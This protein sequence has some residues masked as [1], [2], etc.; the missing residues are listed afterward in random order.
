MVYPYNGII[1]SN[2]KEY[3]QIQRDKK[4]AND[5]LGPEWEQRLTANGHNTFEVAINVLKLDCNDDFTMLLI[6]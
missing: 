4:P 2:K 5:F 1:F 6:Y 3:R